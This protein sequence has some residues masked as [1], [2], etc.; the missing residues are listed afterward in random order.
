MQEVVIF[1]NIRDGRKLGQSFSNNV[2]RLKCTCYDKFGGRY[3]D[4]AYVIASPPFAKG[5]TNLEVARL[6]FQDDAWQFRCTRSETTAPLKQI[7][8]VWKRRYAESFP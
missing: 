2:R 6:K 3:R 1:V 4:F 8:E 7:Y 5:A